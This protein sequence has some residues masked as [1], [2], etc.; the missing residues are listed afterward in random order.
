VSVKIA[1]KYTENK[2]QNDRIP[3]SVISLHVNRSISATKSH[4]LTESIRKDILHLHVVY[5]RLI[6]NPNTQTD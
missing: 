5:K 4:R 3:S 2:F 6:L 1:I